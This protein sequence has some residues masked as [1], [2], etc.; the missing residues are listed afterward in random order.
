MNALTL[1]A[2]LSLILG[3]TGSSNADLAKKAQQLQVT[4]QQKITQL[5]QELSHA[6]CVRR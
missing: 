6:I 5:L 4:E 2:M 3:I 1:S